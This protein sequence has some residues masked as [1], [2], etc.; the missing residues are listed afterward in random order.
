MATRRAVPAAHPN[1]AGGL[2][3]AEALHILR[4]LS[5]GTQVPSD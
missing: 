2:R 4:A 3:Q 1:D 5:P